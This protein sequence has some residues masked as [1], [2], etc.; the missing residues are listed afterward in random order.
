MSVEVRSRAVL[1]TWIAACMTHA[2]VG[3]TWPWLLQQYGIGLQYQDLQ[4]LVLSDRAAVDALLGAAAYIESHTRP[5]KGLFTLADGGAATTLQMAAQFAAADQ[6]M[7]AAWRQ[8]EAAAEARGSKHWAEVQRKQQLAAQKRAE[9]VRLQAAEAEAKRLLDGEEARISS[10]R[11]YDDTDITRY[12]TRYNSAVSAREATE[13]ELED[14]LKPP[15]PV[16]QPLPKQQTPAL[17]WLFFL[18]MP[19][20]LRWVACVMLPLPPC[21][22]VALV[23]AEPNLCCAL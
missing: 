6:H 18:N 2:A 1:A 9:L 14:A 12:R 16:I 15:T 21:R 13:R 22:H 23:P 4:H 10:Y 8:E 17:Q 11:Y 3:R 19:Q 7:L 5:S 20:L